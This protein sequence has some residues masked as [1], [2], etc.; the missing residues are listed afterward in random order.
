MKYFPAKLITNVTLID[1][2]LLK[3]VIKIR[4]NRSKSYESSENFKIANLKSRSL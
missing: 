1:L 2:I 3:N 4:Y